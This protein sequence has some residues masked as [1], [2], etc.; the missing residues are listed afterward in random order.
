V[1]NRGKMKKREE[2]KR[3]RVCVENRE[4]RGKE[5]KV[6]EEVCVWG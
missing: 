2:R 6:G 4:K 3:K 1:Q 5:K